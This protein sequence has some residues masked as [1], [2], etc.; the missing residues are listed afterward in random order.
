MQA[1]GRR[2]DPDYLHHLSLYGPVVRSVVR[3]HSGPPTDYTERVTRGM[4]VSRPEDEIQKQQLLLDLKTW[5]KTDLQI[6]LQKQLEDR[7]LKTEQCNEEVISKATE[8]SFV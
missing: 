2:F 7:T 8:R 4:I 6:W 3:A 1:G 5:R